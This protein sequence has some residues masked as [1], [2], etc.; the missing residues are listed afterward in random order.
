MLSHPW[1]IFIELYYETKYFI[2]RGIRGYSDRDNWSVDGFLLNILPPMLKNLDRFAHGYPV[3][4]GFKRWRGILK[5]MRKGL[6]ANQKLCN[7]TYNWRDKKCQKQLQKES[8]EGLRLF[9]KYFNNL[10]D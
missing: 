5:R 9:G 7:L 10:W 4:I 8:R 1:K 2:Q 3:G 6:L